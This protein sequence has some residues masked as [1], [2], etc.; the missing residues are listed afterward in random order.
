MCSFV[1]SICEGLDKCVIRCALFLF[2]EEASDDECSSIASSNT[3]IYEEANCGDIE[4]CKEGTQEEVFKTGVNDLPAS[5]DV[6][7]LFPKETKLNKKKT[8]GR[9]AP[10]H[11]LSSNNYTTLVGLLQDNSRHVQINT[12]PFSLTNNHFQA[13]HGRSRNSFERSYDNLCNRSVP[14]GKVSIVM[15]SQILNATKTK[16][17]QSEATKKN[18]NQS[19][20]AKTKSIQS[21]A[22]KTKSNQSEAAKA[23]S[24]HSEV[25]RHTLK[26]MNRK[27]ISVASGIVYED[28]VSSFETSKSS[29]KTETLLSSDHSNVSNCKAYNKNNALFI[30]NILTPFR[31]N[32]CNKSFKTRD[33]FMNHCKVHKEEE[34]RDSIVCKKVFTHAS[35]AK[36]HVMTHLD[37]KLFSNVEEKVVSCLELSQSSPMSQTLR[38]SDHSDEAEIVSS[39]D[40]QSNNDN[41]ASSA[42]HNHKESIITSKLL[43]DSV[44]VTNRGLVRLKDKEKPFACLFCGKAYKNRSEVYMHIRL[45]HDEKRYFWEFC[46][47]R[48]ALEGDLSKHVTMHTQEKRFTCDQCG[49]RFRLQSNLR[50]HKYKHSEERIFPCNKCSKSFKTSGSLSVHRASH[51]RED[52]GKGIICSICKYVFSNRHVLKQ[53]MMIHTGE[54][55]FSCTLCDKRFR[56]KVQLRYHVNTHNGKKK[57]ADKLCSLCGKS[58]TANY[59]PIH[60]RMHSGEKPFE[61]SVC[62]KRFPKKINLEGHIR[63]HT[64][65]KPF[66]CSGCDKRFALYSNMVTHKAKCLAVSENVA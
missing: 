40:C 1:L 23:K 55:P 19:E 16:F 63:S 35:T 12:S 3:E 53:H 33:D 59:M 21:E 66:A 8:E 2:T 13:E 28:E 34:L 62:F 18:S 44:F 20:A 25:G 26:S 9:I 17:T 49:K 57:H 6:S 24:N 41:C 58:V 56:L 54:K 64:G 38:S 37:H 27:R 22:T 65:E 45:Q 39:F 61:C 11:A 5:G 10:K 50:S 15:E 32:I 29:T 60:M 30:H 36:Q 46:G 4:I 14:K 7:I 42:F 48:F 47:K 51:K 31:C 43:A 52:Q